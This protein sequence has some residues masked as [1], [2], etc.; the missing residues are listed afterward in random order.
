MASGSCVFGGTAFA[1]TGD[2]ARVQLHPPGARA[3]RTSVRTVTRYMVSRRP[4]GLRASSEPDEPLAGR[5]GHCRTRFKRS[6]P[7]GVRLGWS[8]MGPVGSESPTTATYR[9]LSMPWR[10][11]PQLGLHTGV[12]IPNACGERVM[13]KAHETLCG[14][15]PLELLQ[16]EYKVTAIWPCLFCFYSTSLRTECPRKGFGL[17]QSRPR[18]GPKS[19]QS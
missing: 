7:L 10:L 18:L 19:A 13:K 9:Y 15:P 8:R 6:L 4:T 16:D 5:W 17:V 11:D 3:G 2:A 1:V 14:P 12:W